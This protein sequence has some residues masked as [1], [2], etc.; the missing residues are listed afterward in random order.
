MSRPTDFVRTSL[1][2][3]FLERSPLSVFNI[4]RLRGRAF[5]DFWEALS[6]SSIAQISTKSYLTEITQRLQLKIS[7]PEKIYRPLKAL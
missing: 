5:S 1:R 2:I 6:A 4:K 7:R 3:I